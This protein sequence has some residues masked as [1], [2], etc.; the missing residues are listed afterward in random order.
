M[1]CL[2]MKATEYREYIPA[3]S[4]IKARCQFSG[5]DFKHAVNKWFDTTKLDQNMRDELSKWIDDLESS[6]QSVSDFNFYFDEKFWALEPLD[7]KRQ[8]FYIEKA[9]KL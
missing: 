2:I 7:K 9:C 6:E 5:N 8:S 3:L 1:M 4:I